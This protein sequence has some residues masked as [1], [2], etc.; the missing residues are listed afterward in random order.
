MP[1]K[2]T[3]KFPWQSERYHLKSLVFMEY[4][5]DQSPKS[6]ESYGNRTMLPMTSRYLDL[7]LSG[8]KGLAGGIS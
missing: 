8:E 5:T 4:S 3:L 1:Y 7:N 2:P 6:W